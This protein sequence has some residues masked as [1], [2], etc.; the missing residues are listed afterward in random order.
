MKK[1][2]GWDDSNRETAKGLAIDMSVVNLST[3]NPTWTGSGS[4]TDFRDLKIKV[5]VIYT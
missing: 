1:E 5:Y 4:N 2:Q 3:T